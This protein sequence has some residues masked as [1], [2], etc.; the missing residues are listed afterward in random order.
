MGYLSRVMILL[1]ILPALLLA[2]P[3]NFQD[4][5]NAP[6]SSIMSHLSSSLDAVVSI[7]TEHPPAIGNDIQNIHPKAIPEIERRFGSG[8]FIAKSGLLITNAHVVQGSKTIVI[9]NQNGNEALGYL[10]GL[11]P[12][13]DIAVIQTNMRPSHIISLEDRFEAKIG[14]PV[15]AIGTAFGLPQSVSYGIV[16]ALHRSISN[17]LQDFIQTDSAI[18]QGNSGGPLINKQGKLIG[19]NTMIIGVKGGNNGVGFAIPTSLVRNIAKQI[20]EHGDIKPAQMGI[21]I[22]NTS[23]DMAIALGAPGTTGV[24]VTDI[25]SGSPAEKLGLMNK[26]IIIKLNNH[27][28][29]SS[30][31][32]AALVYSTRTGSDI[33]IDAIRN[34]KPITLSTTLFAPDEKK[35]H[36]SRVLNGLSLTE[37][38][39][40][41]ASGKTITGIGVIEVEPG[42]PG[43]LAGLIPNDLITQIGDKKIESLNDLKSI[44]PTEPTLVE[45]IRQN[46]PGFLVL[47]PVE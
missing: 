31:Q 37:F 21:Q 32:I 42:S 7:E 11:D 13:L 40:I 39:G 26:D 44:T 5:Q 22:Q 19:V 28:I 35:E 15:Y 25:A 2:N 29:T 12:V 20:I 4:S 10:L 8:F 46:K 45:V 47:S 18:N 27:R 36:S 14:E 41:N 1:P 17:P 3:S 43:W 6:E 33:S 23:A 38:K 24:V 34:N 30:A 16:S 9:R